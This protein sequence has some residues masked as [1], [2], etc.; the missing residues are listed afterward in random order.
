MSS[1]FHTRLLEQNDIKSQ[2]LCGRCQLLH[3]IVQTFIICFAMHNLGYEI[4][5]NCVRPRC[6]RHADIRRPPIR[7]HIWYLQPSYV[8]QSCPKE[9]SRTILGN[10]I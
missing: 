5:R 1:D 8:H 10:K 9:S 7:A 4:V 2:V 3:G 6:D